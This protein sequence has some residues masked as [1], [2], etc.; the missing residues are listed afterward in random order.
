MFFSQTIVMWGQEHKDSLYHT[1]QHLD[2][3]TV[4]SKVSTRR[5]AG[6]VNGVQI[7]QQELF[8]AACCNLGESFTT[9]PSVDVS[10]NDAATGARQIKLLGLSGTYVQMLTETM[11]TFRL[12]AA[13]FSLGYVPGTWMK[14]IS[15]SKGA[16][17]VKN[18]Y[19]S[20]TGQIDID[21]LKPE[22]EEKLNVNLYG[23]IQSRLEANADK[24]FNISDKLS[25]NLL[26]HYEN[27]W[28]HHDS[29]GDGFM[30]MPNVTQYNVSNRWRLMTPKYV[31]RFGWSAI[32]EERTSG[33]VHSSAV[34]ASDLY[35][36][37]ITTDRYEGYMKHAFIINPE[38]QMNIALM[39][40]GAIH[41]L[42][43]TY[44]RYYFRPYDVD[45]KELHA[46]L[47][48]EAAFSEHH[49]ISTGLCLNH[50][51]LSQ[52][53]LFHS[54]AGLFQSYAGENAGIEKETTPGAYAQYT[55]TVGT[56][57][58]AMAGIRWDH[59]SL[60]GSFVTPRAHIKYQ[61]LDAVSFRISAG[62]GY[63]TPH[64]LAENHNLLSSGKRLIVGSLSQEEA[65]NYGIS[66]AINLPVR[67]KTL[68]INGEYYFTDFSMQTVIDY[69]AQSGTISI[70][71][72]DGKSFSHVF[73]VDA[74]YPLFKGFDLTAAYRR[75][76]VKCT[77]GGVLKTKPLTSK[78]KALLTASYKD[79]LELWQLDVT[80]QMNGGGRLPDPY[81][82]Y[83]AFEQL[84]AQVTRRFRYFD[85]YVGGENLTNFRQK[86]PILFATNP[87][88]EAFEPTLVYGPIDGAMAYAGVRIKL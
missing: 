86:N 53:A 82:A 42:K 7:T 11:P 56:K 22:D 43:A 57:L 13:P 45:Q 87:W 85:I 66:T 72:L 2:E 31:F 14:G 49:S 4:R 70:H 17:S 33:Q 26:L 41:N 23:D 25:T 24:N 61:P 35:R 51:Y 16:A 59:S 12:A 58:T 54:F 36:I 84:S 1:T 78:Y 9:N 69:E 3:V 39:V 8:R 46:Q 28:G 75:N 74:S 68:K 88:S 63:R 73:Q 83:N 18:G 52:D 27:R 60:Y 32:K 79:N 81:P 62:K 19:E 47:M 80:L 44:G 76:N 30:D 77:Y 15:V 10:Y 38:K 6:A 5:M 21:Y 29:N 67:E 64:A 50:D 37:G 40:N 34:P 71:D 65:W 20:I 55:L 48:Y